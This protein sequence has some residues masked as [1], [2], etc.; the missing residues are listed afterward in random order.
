MPQKNTAG[1]LQKIKLPLFGAYSNRGSDESKDQRFVNVF[2]ESRKI[3]Q[4]DQTR[5]GLVTRPGVTRYKKFKSNELT[6]S[7]TVLGRGIIFFKGHLFVVSNYTLYMDSTLGGLGAITPLITMTTATG[8]VGM[9]LGNSATIG[10]YLFVC[11]GQVGWYI[12]SSFAVHTITDTDFPTP[13][14]TTPVFLDGYICL[15]KGSDIYSCDL[16]TPSSWN[17]SNFVS[18]ESFPDEIIGLARQNN[19]I[20]AFGSTS[21]EF[22]YDA[23][24]ASGSPF[25]RNESAIIQMGCAA[26]FA[27]YQ[28]EKICAFVGQSDSGG[29]S[30]WIIDGF[31]PKR[32]SDEY[33][34]RILDT[35]TNLS[36]CFG[37]GFRSKGH[38]FYLINLTTVNRTIVYDLDEKLWHEWNSGTPTIYS[39]WTY[40]V[41]L[42]NN[43]VDC[44]TGTVYIQSST[45]GYV[46]Y[47]D[48]SSS[49]DYWP[50]YD[51]TSLINNL[52]III[53]TNRI[54]MD[55]INRKRLHSLRFFID[56]DFTLNP[57]GYIILAWSDDDYTNFTSF[58]NRIYISPPY[59]DESGCPITYQLGSFRRRAFEIRCTFPMPARFEAIEL[60]YTEG[61]S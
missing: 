51:N 52:Y 44:G 54:D 15:A 42:W 7:T 14:K 5:V 4:L 12:D 23:A 26:P 56:T 19:Q 10:D 27:I 53:R 61:I 49:I 47:L 28:N 32:I 45:R 31:Q 9:V 38:L 6:D 60:C 2:P 41:F 50:Q 16:D 11:D 17:A 58:L 57:G 8:I 39:T 40:G 13:H 20:V 43:A 21:T 35:E 30:I 59:I 29:R 1:L 36:T 34:D 37:F 24:N 46:G 48:A 22:F 25:N 55:T 18:A 33:I 3:E